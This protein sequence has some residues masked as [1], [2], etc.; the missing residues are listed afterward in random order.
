MVGD[1]SA[2]EAAFNVPQL[3]YF[4]GFMS[5]FA[6]VWLFTISNAREFAAFVQQHLP[7]I[8]LLLLVMG[9]TLRRLTYI[10]PYLLADNRHYTFYV[11]RR[12]FGREGWPFV[13]YLG[14]P[15]YVFA[16]FAAANSLRDKDN[17]WKSL[18]AF[19]VCLSLVPQQLL[20]FRY[21]LLPYI[22][23]RL[24]VSSTSTYQYV[25]EFLFNVAINAFTLY[26]FLYKPFKWHDNT[27]LQRFMW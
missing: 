16:A 10:H 4:M 11:W 2:H 19:C 13:P 21:F 22:V 17:L 14:L 7:K 25:I 24:N 26:M 23:W 15:V 12:V 5:V 20:E 1:R 9:L 18:Y 3:F 27:L 6:F 8:A